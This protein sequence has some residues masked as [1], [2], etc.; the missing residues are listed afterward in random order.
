M[1][2][3][4]GNDGRKNDEWRWRVQ[5]AP[6]LYKSCSGTKD[7]AQNFG[8][9]YRYDISVSDIWDLVAFFTKDPDRRRCHTGVERSPLT[10]VIDPSAALAETIC[11]PLVVA[12]A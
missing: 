2:A 7:D 8:P 6:V 4:L 9:K 1:L 3:A 5:V 10:T 11:P 12:P